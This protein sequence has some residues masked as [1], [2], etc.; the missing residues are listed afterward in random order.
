MLWNGW[1]RS[2]MAP[3]SPMSLLTGVTRFLQRFIGPR[4][5]YLI[6]RPVTLSAI[7]IVAQ[8]I[9]THY[10]TQGYPLA[11]FF[12]LEDADTAGNLIVGVFEG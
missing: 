8:A 11:R 10:L 6:K 5:G 12:A 9:A 7:A 3:C 1:H 2:A 4:R